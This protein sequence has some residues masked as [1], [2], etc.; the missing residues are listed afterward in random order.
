MD[1]DRNDALLHWLF[2]QTQGDAWFRPSEESISSGVALRVSDANEAPEFRVFPY[3]NETLELFET[4]VCAL[5]PL[6]AV[7]VRSAAVHAALAQVGDVI[8]AALKL[9]LLLGILF[10]RGD[11]DAKSIY[12]D[13]NTRIQIIDT[14]LFLPQADREQCAAFVRDERVLV[15]WSESLERIVPTCHDFDERLIKLLWRTK[16]SAPGGASTPGSS[17][18]APSVDGHT[19]SPSADGQHKPALS[20]NV[21]NQAIS[22]RNNGVHSKVYGMN[23]EEKMAAEDGKGKEKEGTVE[24]TIEGAVSVGTHAHGGNAKKLKR[25][26]YGKAYYVDDLEGQYARRRPTRLYAPFYNGLSAAL[27][28]VFIGN[29][30]RILLR[31]YTLDGDFMRFGLVILAPFL[32]CVSLFFTMQM[33]TNLSMIVGPI[34]HYHSNSTYYSALPPPPPRVSPD[35]GESLPHITIQMPVYKE[36]LEGVIKPS[37]ESLKKAMQTYARQGGSSGLFVCDDGMRL[38]SP[39]DRDE[40]IVFY[41]NHNIGWVARP[42]HDSQPGGFTRAGRFKKASN[43]NYGL[44][45]SLKAEKHLERLLA[46]KAAATVANPSV[47]PSAGDKQTSTDSQWGSLSGHS[48]IHQSTP[49][50]PTSPRVA[51]IKLNRHGLQYQN[52]NGSD[53]VI[54]GVGP[55]AATASIINAIPPSGSASGSTHAHGTGTSTPTQH[56][57]VYVEEEDLEERALALAIEETYL[58]YSQSSSTDNK[59]TS[60]G[61]D[62]VNVPRPWAANGRALRIG[63]FLLL[64]D[65]DTV[66]PEDCLRDAVREFR[67]P[68][69]GDVA[70]GRSGGERVGIIQ[71]ESDVMQVF[72]VD[73]W[74]MHSF[75]IL[76]AT[77]VVFWGSGTVG[78]TLLEYRLG[79]KKL[80]PALFE[81]I[82]WIP[83]FFFFFGGLS[84]PLTQAILAHL[85]SYNIQWTA[86]I[87]EVERSNFFKEIPKIWRRFWFSILWR[88]GGE[89]GWAVILPLAMSAACHILFP[90]VLNP[91]LMVFSY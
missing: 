68:S 79:H 69:D 45:L 25:T 10:D 67:E 83:F 7:K 88:I 54:W 13:A 60:E 65:S 78:Y 42:K 12:V 5:N 46:E 48:Q 6:V 76:L 31:E 21:S 14:M 82:L 49:P 24:G 84:I 30:I 17:S 47:S 35:T 27:S 52:H 33:I 63:E 3:E 34:A 1:Y 36:S 26:W 72:P 38:L 55:S 62:G 51:N 32:F 64:V 23:P 90:I 71:H 44:A 89:E 29:G 57:S 58:E 8:S 9:S 39:K 18:L 85:F 53:S 19:P 81:N 22:L 61:Q 11:P 70:G 80:L 77:S 91:W 16:P 41:A 87:K 86:T 2:R 28:F 75:E 50:P 43:M 15:I 20:R 4:A 59:N 74:F 73:G 66:V 56:G 37:V 40:R